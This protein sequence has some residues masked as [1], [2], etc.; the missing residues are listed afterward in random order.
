MKQPQQVGDPF[1]ARNLFQLSEH[2]PGAALRAVR[3]FRFYW[4]DGEFVL[5]HGPDDQIEPLDHLVLAHVENKC[6]KESKT[7]SGVDFVTYFDPMPSSI[8]R[9]PYFYY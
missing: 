6:L 8:Y 9:V 7:G 5:V 4:N 2:G 3:Q 1:I